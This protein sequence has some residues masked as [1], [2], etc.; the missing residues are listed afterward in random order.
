MNQQE[1]FEEKAR[2]FISWQSSNIED[3]NE[4]ALISDLI[5]L[6]SEVAEA[7]KKACLLAIDD[8]NFNLCTAMNLDEL[9]VDIAKAEIRGE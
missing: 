9:I 4:E 3:G 7:Q 1:Y 5:I 8:S 2:Y 6:L